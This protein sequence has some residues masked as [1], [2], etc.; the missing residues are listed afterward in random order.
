[1]MFDEITKN[2]I[3]I[4]CKKVTRRLYNPNR[5]PAIP[6]HEGGKPHKIKIDRTPVVYGEIEITACYTSTLGD[7]TEDD[8]H[9]EGFN[10]LHD[11]KEYF[12]QVNGHIDDDELIWVVEF[13]PIWTYQ[14]G[15]ILA[16]EKCI[17][18]LPPRFRDEARDVF[19][20]LDDR[21]LTTNVKAMDE[22]WTYY[23][24]EAIDD[25]TAEER[26]NYGF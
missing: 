4:A 5:R 18:S 7:M 17:Q 16:A 14:P 10:T 3:C 2:A 15:V 8:A 26:E 1:M 21:P 23:L 25:M 19:Y 20:D 24:C 12:Y 13:E 6:A 22:A 11:Y 9:R